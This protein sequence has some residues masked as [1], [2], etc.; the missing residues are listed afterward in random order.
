MKSVKTKTKTELP[1]EIWKPIKGYEG[2]YEAST[3]GRI[4][5]VKKNYVSKV[6][7]SSDRHKM[8]VL[9]RGFETNSYPVHRVIAET[10]IPNPENLP[11]VNHID[12]IKCHNNVENLEWVS[13]KQN[14]EHALM[15][16]LRKKRI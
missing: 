5:D 3:W 12:G 9:T 6:D 8:I 1:E 10:F 2:L 11:I 15:L 13:H 16:G 14:N 7:F 4:K